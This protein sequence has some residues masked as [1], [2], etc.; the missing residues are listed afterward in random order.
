MRTALIGA[1]IAV[2]L[3]ASGA[4]ATEAITVER[5]DPESCLALNPAQPKCTFEVTSESMSQTI[6]GAVG[7]GSWKVIVK[8]GKTKEVIAPSGSEPEPIAFDYEIGDKVTAIAAPRVHG[9][10]RDTTDRLATSA[11][12]RP[13]SSR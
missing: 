13:T 2:A 1:V 5:E 11:T 6:T 7:Q 4:G 9:C 12:P 3:L 8:R 10:S